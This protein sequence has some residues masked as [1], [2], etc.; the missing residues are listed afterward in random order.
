[1]AHVLVCDFSSKQF[2]TGFA[3]LIILDLEGSKEGCSHRWSRNHMVHL[4]VG[5][6]V[7]SPT[8]LN[9]CEKSPAKY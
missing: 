2:E 4:I 8:R 7:K 9:V 1:M 6:N 5:Y 3:P